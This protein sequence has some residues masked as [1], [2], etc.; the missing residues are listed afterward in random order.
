MSQEKNWVAGCKE[1]KINAGDGGRGLFREREQQGQRS[2]GGKPLWGQRCIKGSFVV[3]F[4]RT[5]WGRMMSLLG[6]WALYWGWREGGWRLLWTGGTQKGLCCINPALP[7][8]RR[9]HGWT[10][11]GHEPSW[12]A[13]VMLWYVLMRV[14]TKVGTVGYLSPCDGRKRVNL[15]WYPLLCQP[16]SLDGQPGFGHLFPLPS[17]VGCKDH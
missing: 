6:V 1:G 15:S 11:L 2:R 3:K 16:H 13:A 8:A 4:R 5:S 12:E 10:G 9:K 14:W 7:A 17:D